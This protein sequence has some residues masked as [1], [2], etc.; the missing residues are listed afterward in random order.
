MIEG[1]IDDER[2]GPQVDHPRFA[3]MFDR[4]ASSAPGQKEF[5]ELRR[6]TAGR[7]RGVILEVGA[8]G[9]YNFAYYDPALAGRVEATEP[10]ETMLAYARER[11]ARAAVP[12]TLTQAP[13][14]ALPFDDGM[15][16]TVVVTLVFCSVVDVPR[17]LS[18]IARVLK[19]GGRLLMAEHVRSTNAALAGV[20]TALLPLTVR[21]A[22]NCHWNR[23]TASAVRQAGFQDMQSRLIPY[24]SRFAQ[25]INGSLV[26]ILLIEASRS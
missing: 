5:G 6:E 17:G 9:G 19:P 18:E 11:A 7:A 24:P 22:G 16:D 23:D 12:I 1:Q 14:E 26:P 13:A 2:R 25:A 3:R 21:V 15:F 10:D 8:G 4:M 20:Q